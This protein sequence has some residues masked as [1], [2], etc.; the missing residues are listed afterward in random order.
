[1]FALRSPISVQVSKNIFGII[2]KRELSE[3]ALGGGGVG[4]VRKK[5]KN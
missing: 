5:F 1:M 3:K 4:G 2:N